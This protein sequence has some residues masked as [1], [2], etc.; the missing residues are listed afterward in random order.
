M[1]ARSAMP[2]DQK[3]PRTAAPETRSKTQKTVSSKLPTVS[4]SQATGRRLSSVS[5]TPPS[6]T[7]PTSSRT[8]ASVPKS[9]T[10]SSKA[11]DLEFLSPAE[12]RQLQARIAEKLTREKKQDHAAKDDLR[13]LLEAVKVEATKSLGVAAYSERNLKA[14]TPLARLACESVSLMIDTIFPSLTRV[15]RI[16]AYRWVVECARLT[17]KERGAKAITMQTLLYQLNDDPLRVVEE[18]FPGYMKVGLLETVFKNY[19]L[20]KV[21]PSEERK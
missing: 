8:L 21:K 12:L 5:R 17:M 19:C 2:G 4:P 10:S 20:T 16:Q 9:S 11:V 3:V 1:S 6:A 18:S 15:E 13:L 14:L 7:T